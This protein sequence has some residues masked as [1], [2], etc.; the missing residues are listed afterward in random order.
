MKQQTDIS[1]FL[2]YYKYNYRGYIIHRFSLF[3]IFAWQNIVP[4][5]DLEL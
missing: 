3:L 2:I 5:M 1:G 4:Q